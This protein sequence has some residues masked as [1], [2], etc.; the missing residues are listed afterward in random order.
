MEMKM[1]AVRYATHTDT[2]YRYLLVCSYVLHTFTKGKFHLRCVS[3]ILMRFC[4]YSLLLLYLRWAEMPIEATFNKAPWRCPPPGLTT[5]GLTDWRTDGWTDGQTVCMTQVF[6][7]G[8]TRAEAENWLIP[9][10]EWAA[11]MEMEAKTTRVFKVQSN[12][13]GIS[14]DKPHTRAYYVRFDRPFFSTCC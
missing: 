10:S 6:F 12:L 2:M 13:R 5:D 9:L 11:H 4:C 7:R 3:R 1:A 8:A 14:V